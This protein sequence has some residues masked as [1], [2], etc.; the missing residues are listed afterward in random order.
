MDSPMY[1]SL[2]ASDVDRAKAWYKDH[3]GLEP[4]EDAPDGGAIYETGGARFAIYPSAFA[5]TNQATAGGFAV[6]DFDAAMTELRGNG[7][8]FEEYDLG[9]DLKTVDGVVTTPSGNRAAWFRDS[10]GNIIGVFEE[11]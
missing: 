4:I 11:M 8:I 5:G 1:A 10:E 3:L 2:P 9:D 7:L 6:A